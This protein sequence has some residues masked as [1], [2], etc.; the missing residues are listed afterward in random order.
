MGARQRHPE[1]QDDDDPGAPGSK[2]RDP[3]LRSLRAGSETEPTPKELFKGSYHPRREPATGDPPAG[4]MTIEEARRK[5]PIGWM[6]LLGPGLITGASDDDP[7]GIGTYSQVGSQ[8]GYGFLWTSLFTFPL[9]AAVQELCAR[10]A[11]HTGVG[12]GVAL[13]RKFPRPL[14]GVCIAALFVANTI[15][16]G[17]D[18]GAI[19]AGGSL[20][21]R[22]A[23]HLLW[24]V[25][26]A[27]A[28]ILALQVFMTYAVIFKVF[29]WLTV[30]LFAYVITGFLVHP[31]LQQ[32]V[33]GSLIPHVEL[34][35]DSIAA[36]VAIL[37]TTISPYLFFWQAS[38]EVDDMRAAGKVREVAR[39]G[40]RQSE[41]SAARADIVIGMF[42]S[43]LVMFF[44]ILTTAAVLH[45]HGKT[46]IQTASQAAE[47]LAP[48]AGQW[49]FVLFAAGII[50][51]G[52]LAVPILTA[53]AAY[54]VKEF[55][56]FEGALAD[57]PWYRPTFYAIMALATVAGVALNLLGLDPI[58]ALFVSAIINGL[59]APPLLVLIV[60]LGSDRGIMGK[61]TSGWVSRSL[62]WATTAVM[63]AAAAALLATLIRR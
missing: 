25:V 5:G 50:G 51:T 38:S 54:A 29:K 41:L 35:S 53:S 16:A 1:P 7:S 26:P 31:Q 45:G 18:L 59:V 8:F 58:R 47:A 46:D 21:T 22:G 9:M 3:I 13:R 19:A 44:I 63:S 14:V 39:R 60:L 56:G 55:M 20:L 32:V 12:L 57:K 2:V 37:G 61:R 52:L 48:L 62:T 30:A 36:L 15:N 43:N 40:V 6:Q 42:F 27:A 11:L 33:T 4:R 24:F 17:A 10:I 28:L 23:V 34:T 49:A